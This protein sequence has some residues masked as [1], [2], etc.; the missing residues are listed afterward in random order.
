MQSVFD[1]FK[2]TPY[3]FLTIAQSRIK[4][5][6]ITNER[7]LMGIFKDKSGSVQNGNMESI[8]STATLHV[9][10]EDFKD[11]STGQFIGQGVRINGVDYAISGATAGMNYETGELEHY[12]LTLQKANFI[13]ESSSES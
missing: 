4:G 8:E 13:K 2:Q 9:H 12:R 3:V 7:G 6:T 10:P 11:W 1:V 5:D